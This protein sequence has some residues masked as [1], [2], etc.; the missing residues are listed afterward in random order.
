MNG[1][2]FWLTLVTLLGSGLMAGTFFAFSVLVMKPLAGRP[3]AEAIPVMQA[4][5]RAAEKPTFL[6]AFLGTGLAS[7]ALAIWAPIRGGEDFTPFLI[8]G[9]SL[10]F[11]GAFVETMAY[12]VPRNN[13]LDAVDP[14]ASGTS[15]LWA[16]FVPGWTAMNH[17]RA[18]AAL[19][20]A[21]T[22]AGA[23]YAA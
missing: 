2:L 6:L 9:G 21:A 19:A 18:V 13:A 16:E 5:N 20:A 11:I 4:I 12:H 3:A 8:V 22:L 23:L 7:A 1:I 14:Q 17:V 15:K 10:Y